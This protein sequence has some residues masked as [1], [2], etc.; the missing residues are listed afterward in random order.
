MSN[1]I[2]DLQV[3]DIACTVLQHTGLVSKFCTFLED[4]ESLTTFQN[5]FPI[6]NKLL[7]EVFGEYFVSELEFKLALLQFLGIA[8]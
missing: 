4:Q 8:E 5:S 7:V 3:A 2:G 6:R 1:T